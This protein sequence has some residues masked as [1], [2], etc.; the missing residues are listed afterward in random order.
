MESHMSSPDAKLAL[1]FP[2][3]D[4][5][6]GGGTE[7]VNRVTL[8]RKAGGVLDSSDV[9]GVGQRSR[10]QNDVGHSPENF[11]FRELIRLDAHDAVRLS[12]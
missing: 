5:R 6:G 11:E 4:S 9:I 7:C 2:V 12:R 1:F 3:W 8:G 10:V